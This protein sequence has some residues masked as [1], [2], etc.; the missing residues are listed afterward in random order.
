VHLNAEGL[1]TIE[2]DT[3]CWLVQY[4]GA[5]YGEGRK[6]TAYVSETA[7]FVSLISGFKA[8]SGINS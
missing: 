1:T 8:K 3:A 5:V 6:T 7:I 2:R 4:S